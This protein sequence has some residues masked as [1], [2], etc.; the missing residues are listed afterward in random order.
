MIVR[1]VVAGST[2]LLGWELAMSRC[3]GMFALA[4]ALATISV[5]AESRA[6]ILVR[7][8]KASQRMLVMVN[9]EHRHTWPVSTGIYGTPSGNFRPQALKRY[10]RST[11]YNGAPMPYSIFYDGN[12]AIHGTTHVRQLGGRASRGCIRLHPANAAVLFSL[13]QQYGPGR[14]QIVIQ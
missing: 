13:V 14:T 3:F 4:F 2:D 6:D 5:P 11:I 8:E 7:V 10:H 12:F 9:G 1:I